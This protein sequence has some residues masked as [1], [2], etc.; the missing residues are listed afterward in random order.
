[1]IHEWDYIKYLFGM[2]DMVHKVITRVSDLEID[3]DDIACYIGE[4]RDKIVE[5]HLDYFGR[6]PIREMQIYTA[7]ETIECDLI[8]SQI[9][10][11]KSGKVIDLTE[12]RNDF[13][14]SE[15]KHFLDMVEHKCNNE[16]TMQDAYK[17]LLLTQGVSR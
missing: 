15:L 13:Q 7:K 16:N 9:R 6:V 12:E 17:T 11:L 3:S 14:I 8:R 4:Y 10:Y 2:P 5:L 1:M